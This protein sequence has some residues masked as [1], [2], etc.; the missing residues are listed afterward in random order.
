MTIT[1]RGAAT[2][3]AGLVRYQAGPTLTEEALQ[4]PATATELAGDR[5][6]S[7]TLTGLRADTRYAY[8]VGDGRGWST[9]RAFTTADPETRTV[10]F[11]LFGDSQSVPPYSQW[12]RTVQNAFKAHP[13]A[14]FM[15][16]VGDLVD[17]GASAAH[18]H[19][20]FSAAEGVI[21]TIPVM[22]AL[23][24]H[25]AYPLTSTAWRAYWHTQFRLPQNGPAIVKNQAYSFDYGPLHLVMLDSQQGEQRWAGDILTPQRKWLDLDLA[26]TRA[27]WKL[28]FF[29][30]GPYE[31]HGG[32]NAAVKAAFCPTLEKRGVA[33]VFSGHDH[34]IAR[35]HPLK[36]NARVAPADGTVYVTSGRSG[37]KTYRDLKAHAHHAFFSNPLDQPN[38]LVIEA[39]D[40]ELTVRAVKQDG[41]LIDRFTVEKAP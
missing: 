13:D 5:I 30:K 9:V 16:S 20:W 3:T 37:T 35:T 11:L 41:T 7:A 8:R 19:A 14:R 4:A 21:D 31:L 12:R 25:E 40:R 23:G 2:A 27:P 1:W 33:V 36:A 32:G 38:Y 39:T 22:P 15:V 17:T 10:K 26:K 18:W 24:N 28:A 6:F 34:G 29:H